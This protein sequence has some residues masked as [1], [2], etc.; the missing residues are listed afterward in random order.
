MPINIF[1]DTYAL[2]AKTMDLRSQRHSLISSNIAEIITIRAEAGD[3]SDEI[4]IEFTPGGITL[5]AIPNTAIRT[6]D[7]QFVIGTQNEGL[8]MLNHKGE[9]MMKIGKA[10]KTKRHL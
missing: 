1:G 7:G 3:Y 5:E 2:L 4:Q 6:I 8:F 9:L 10:F